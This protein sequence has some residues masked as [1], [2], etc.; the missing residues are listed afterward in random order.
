MPETNL[1]QI[2]RY[3]IE[4]ALSYEPPDQRVYLARDEQLHRLV[5]IHVP[6]GESIGTLEEQQ[7]FLAEARAVASLEHPHIVPIFDVGNSEEVPCYLVSKYVDGQPISA[8][9]ARERIDFAEVADLVR[10]IAMALHHVHQQGLIHGAVSPHNILLD[11]SGTPALA[12]F[13][14]LRRVASNRIVDVGSAAYLSPE[15]I[16]GETHRVDCRSDLFSL[17]VVLYELLTGVLPFQGSE[18]TE[19]VE[20][21]STQEAEL[22]EQRYAAIPDELR[23]IC[24]KALSKRAMDRFSSGQEFAEELSEFL[25][26]QD[27]ALVTAAPNEGYAEQGQPRTRSTSSLP[28]VSAPSASRRTSRV[29]PKG[30]KSFDPEDA[31]FFLSLLPGPRDRHGCPESIRFWKSR[32]E[33]TESS[34]SVGVVYGPSGC[35]KSSLVKAGL[36]PRLANNVVSIYVE[37]T[38]RDTESQLLQ[39]VRNR[40]ATVDEDLSLPQTLAA[41]RRG[42]GLPDGA[43]VLLVVDQFEQWL[44]AHRESQGEMLADA[45][46]HCDGE[47][48]QCILMVRDDF[49]MATTRFMREV[50]VPLVEGEN[51]AAVDL[52]SLRHAKRVLTELGRAYSA[53]DEELSTLDK[54]ERAFLEQAVTGLAE[55]GRIVP[56]RLALFAEMMKGRPWDLATLEKLGGTRG[57]GTRFLDET[58]SASTAPPERRYHQ[59]AARAV[60]K[61]LLPGHGEEIRGETKTHDDLLWASGYADRPRDFSQL[62]RMLDSELRLITP[63]AGQGEDSA[64]PTDG[65]TD[66][67]RYQLT[68]DYLVPSLREWLA[69]KQQETWR[70]RAE[71]RLVERTDIWQRRGGR[72]HLPS[73]WEFANLRLGTDKR[74]WNAQERAMMTRA[75]R[76]L[77]LRWG[78][79][80]CVVAAFT[81]GLYR[82]FSLAE[83]AELEHREELAVTSITTASATEVDDA[84]EYVERFESTAV[85]RLR[86]A[87]ATAEHRGERLRAAVGLAAFG[88]HK[89]QYLVGAVAEAAPDERTLIFN[90]L[91]DQRETAIQL[92]REEVNSLGDWSLAKESNQAFARLA[93]AI[94]AQ[95]IQP[96][97]RDNIQSPEVLAALAEFEAANTS[98]Q[99]GARQEVAHRNRKA[100]L[101]ITLLQL[102]EDDLAREMCRIGAN[103]IQR[104]AFINTFDEWPCDPG[105]LLEQVSDTDR[106]E[107]RSAACFA[108]GTLESIEDEDRM[109]WEPRLRRWYADPEP[110]AHS[111]AVW[112]R[113]RWQLPELR[114]R[115]AADQA[116]W[117]RTKATGITMIRI[118]RGKFY[119]PHNGLS[120]EIAED[121]WLCDREVTVQ[122]FREFIEDSDYSGLKLRAWPGESAFD[123]P[124]PLHPVQ[125]VSWYDAVMFCNWLS[126]R[127]GKQPC[128]RIEEQL[129]EGTVAED[130]V[131]TLNETSDGFRLPT[132]SEWQHACRSG[133]TH[134]YSFGA[135]PTTGD[136]FAV[137]SSTSD[138][139][140]AQGG[141]KMCNSWG[142]FDMHGNVW[143]WCWDAVGPAGESRRA[144]SGSYSDLLHYS[145]SGNPTAWRPSLRNIHTGFR[146]AAPVVSEN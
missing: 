86:E 84:I 133:T 103:T 111:A 39:R 50:D 65:G 83:A 9:I 72:R 6:V 64:A 101:A 36:L 18:L 19:L 129:A 63:V 11:K 106:A 104:T 54:T 128:Y 79:L 7:A 66:A 43:K 118:P 100:R 114:P 49:W 2:S 27:A 21:I 143:E 52:F 77:V 126:W 145:H 127:E 31:D 122:L 80:F 142:L 75:G 109:A 70:G 33:Q 138:A 28:T 95:P 68:H 82:H 136:W 135:V 67:Y 78:T 40:L 5:V 1:Q 26:A 71:L 105:K 91:E 57:V 61:S 69:S 29:I 81:F 89:L 92:L 134:A 146:V 94:D 22:L 88:Q 55:N 124:T 4:R 8:R 23:R 139:T 140:T 74:R 12:N 10:L 97:S 112:L 37:S 76:Y 41:L 62:L 51:A 17:G 137:L 132:A 56:V 53:W 35:G 113:R 123:S 85:D 90:A 120:V 34:F 58:F 107:W 117:E 3:R 115:A 14:L 110:L 32:I 16:R 93:D 59:P 60:L 25:A 48:L 131:V 24:L 108:V 96:R 141:T 98:R 125:R 119:R 102:G 38:P 116:G 30:L 73:S 87:F 44:H 47:K 42:Q 20:Q 45:L 13:D 99:R 46:R 15:Q 121:F 144:A 130:L